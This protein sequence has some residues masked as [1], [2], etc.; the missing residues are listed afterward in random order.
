VLVKDAESITYN[1]LA[2][3]TLQNIGQEALLPFVK[4][5]F[6]PVDW[7]MRAGGQYVAR[8]DI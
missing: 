2:S 5:T 3:G 1:H 4:V 6:L 7:S 8:E